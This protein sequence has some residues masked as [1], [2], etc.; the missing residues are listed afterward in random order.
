MRTGMDN[1]L[2]AQ[3]S[4]AF[5]EFGKE[6]CAHTPDCANCFIKDECNFGS[7]V[8]AAPAKASTKALTDGTFAVV[9]G[10][11]DREYTVTVKGSKI[12]CNCKGYR[13]KRTCSHV[14]TIAE[15][16]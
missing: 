4:R 11:S 2:L 5:V 7:G 14:K 12:S 1:F 3:Y 9:A 6:T 16:A 10:S 13:F 8:K 15:A